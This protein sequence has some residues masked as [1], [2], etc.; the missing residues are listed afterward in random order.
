MKYSD[1]HL[2]KGNDSLYDIDSLKNKNWY[3][4]Y[5]SYYNFYLYIDDVLFLIILL[6]YINL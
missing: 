3:L 4:K 5:K 1:E 6:F 2:T